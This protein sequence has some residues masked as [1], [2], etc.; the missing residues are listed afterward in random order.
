MMWICN[1]EKL[2]TDLDGGDCGG[3][4][5]AKVCSLA[6]L[7]I[8]SAVAIHLIDFIETS[9]RLNPFEAIGIPQEYPQ[10]RTQHP[11]SAGT[12][13][14]KPEAP[15]LSLPIARKWPYAVEPDTA[16][17]SLHGASRSKGKTEPARGRESWSVL[18]QSNG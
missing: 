15:G 18:R 13:S 4:F 12:V 10:A 8:A 3:C 5:W 1:L 11:A 7:K 6:E 14:A 2:R 17:K 9:S 16:R